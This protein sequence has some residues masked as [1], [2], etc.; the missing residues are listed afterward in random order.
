MKIQCEEGW[1]NSFCPLSCISWLIDKIKGAFFLVLG[2]LSCAHFLWRPRPIRLFNSPPITTI[3]LEEEEVSVGIK[4]EKLIPLVEEIIKLHSPKVVFLLGSCFVEIQKIDLKYLAHFLSQYFKIWFIPVFLSGFEK[5]YTCGEDALLSSLVDYCPLPSEE[6]KEEVVFLG[7]LSEKSKN[8]F[9]EKCK[10]LNI[11]LG[12]FLPPSNIS[13]LPSI[14]EKTLICPLTPYLVFTLDKIAQKRKSNILKSLFPI[15]I[16]GCREFWKDICK[17]F[18]TSYEVIQEKEEQVREMLEKEKKYIKNKKIFFM[19]D[20]LLELPLARFIEF[21]EGKILEMG[22]PYIHFVYHKKE[23]NFLEK[24]DI[25]II[26][27]PNN[28]S[29]LERIK[30]LKPD[31]VVSPLVFSYPLE[32]SM[33]T[34][35]VWSVKFFLSTSSIYDFESVLSLLKIFTNLLKR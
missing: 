24:K 27:S 33:K 29:Q 31:L 13:N 1:Y 14:G 11:P 2:S 6:K 34:K 4:E 9:I 3:V 19:G 8:T 22:T 16:Q 32:K 28:F 17:Y 20:N 30:K 21:C 15:G 5:A 18:K 10:I 23:L 12:G 25:T 26:E 7:A 35:S